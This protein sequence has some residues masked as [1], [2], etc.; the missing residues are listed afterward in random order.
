[1]KVQYRVQ[2]SKYNICVECTKCVINKGN[3][4]ITGTVMMSTF[5]RY[6][7]V[8]LYR[9]VTYCH[10][11]IMQLVHVHIILSAV[12]GANGQPFSCLL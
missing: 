5:V 7:E 10:R 6:S 4:Q 2:S 3:Q 12:S 1:M 8:L 9:F 11:E